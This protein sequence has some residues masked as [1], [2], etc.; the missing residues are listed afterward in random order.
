MS[1]ELTEVRSSVAET[2]ELLGRVPSP[3]L[4]EVS[5]R[6]VEAMATADVVQALEDALTQKQW[7]RAVQL[8][9][10]VRFRMRYMYSRLVA[11]C[12]FLSPEGRAVVW[13]CLAI[14]KMM[15]WTVCSTSMP[16]I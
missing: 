13:R 5:H 2:V 11:C 8:L 1:Q 12:A 3:P 6:Q 10:A 14:Q 16:T 4:D 9:R 15:M 7:S